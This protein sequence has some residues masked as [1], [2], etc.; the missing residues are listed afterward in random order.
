MGRFRFVARRDEV[1][2]WSPTLAINPAAGRWLLVRAVDGHADETELARF[3]ASN[4]VGARWSTLWAGLVRA[5]LRGRAGDPAGAAAAFD[6]AVSAGGPLPLFC[7]LGVR[8]ACEPAGHDGWGGP[9]SALTTAE[10]FLATARHQPG[11]PAC[12]SPLARPGRAPP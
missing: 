7:H 1:S 9:V 2:R 12:R 10:G 4:A 8:L 11:A 6:A 5:V 3:E